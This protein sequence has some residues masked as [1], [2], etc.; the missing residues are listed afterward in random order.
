MSDRTVSINGTVY[1]RHTGLPVRLERDKHSESS[2][3]AHQVHRHMQKSKTL[4]RKYVHRDREG[5]IARS[6]DTQE[7]ERHAIISHRTIKA[8]ASVTKHEAITHHA[9]HDKPQEVRSH[10][11]TI[12][13]IGPTPHIIAGRAEHQLSKSKP[14]AVGIK[15]S[16]ILK[17]EAIERA[18]SQTPAKHSKKPASSARKSSKVR[19]HIS[20]ASASLAI[21]LLGAYFTYLSMPSLSTRVAAIQAG[22]DAS[23]PG[24]QPTGYALSGPVAFQEGKVT[25][26]FAANAGPVSYTLTQTKSGWDSSAVLDYFVKPRAGNDY[27]TTMSSGLTVYSYGTN[28][29]WVNKGIFYSITGNAPLSDDQIQHIVTSL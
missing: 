9:S 5:A 2:K 3:N 16:Q 8:P 21:I 14:K 27:T 26:T 10:T 7:P 28:T 24:Y 29:A 11:K 12:S 22:I 20:L 17:Q 25:M 1:D 4:S 13:D 15:P 19:R 23:Y 18:M 6:T